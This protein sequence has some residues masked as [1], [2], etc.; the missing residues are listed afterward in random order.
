[1]KYCLCACVLFLLPIFKSQAQSET[2]TDSI[3]KSLISKALETGYVETPYFNFDL[4]YLVKYN[5]YEG[6]RTGIGGITNS[7]LSEL[8]RFEGYAVYGFLDNA[9]KYSIGTGVRLAKKT[10]TW[11]N[12]SYT[13]D[14][15]ET[16]S[17]KF[18]TDQRFFQ[19]FEPRLINIESFFRHITKAVSLEHQLVP[20]ILTETQF[21]TSRIEPK[22]DYVY[23]HET[24]GTFTN[25]KLSLLTVSTQL[26]LFSKFEQT[27]AGIVETKSGFPKCTIQ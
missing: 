25:Y 14:L 27:P 26:S 23:N 8:I 20:E 15:Q 18:L 21:A 5:Q 11:L 7:N 22:Y 9:F 19:L 1:M 10:H 17:S 24:Q 3:P 2:Q 12:L 4:R 16:G 13:D 6:F